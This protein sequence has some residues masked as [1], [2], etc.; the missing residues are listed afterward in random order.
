MVVLMNLNDFYAF[1]GCFGLIWHVL[2]YPKVSRI[3]IL[4]AKFCFTLM[5]FGIFKTNNDNIS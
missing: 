3:S 1:L 5:S 2:A 4:N